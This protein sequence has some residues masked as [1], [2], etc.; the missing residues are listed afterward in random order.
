MND[1][2]ILTRKIPASIDADDWLAAIV[3]SSDDAIISK[4]LDGIITSWNN[5][6]ERIFGYKGDE[7]LG[8][9]ITILIPDRLL[10]QEEEI[11]QRIRT[12]GRVV[13][14]ETVRI[15]KD[16]SEIY[17]SLTISPIYDSGG[18]IAGISKIARDITEQ[19]LLKERE[20]QARA[21]MLVERRFRELIE[22]AP[23][24]ILQ[25]DALGKITIANQSAE[26]MFGYPRSELVGSKVDL[27]VPVASR[28]H[29]ARYRKTFSEAGVSRPMGW[30][31][32]LSARR[33]DGSEFPVEISLSPEQTEKGAF[34]TA[35]IRDVTDRKQA[36]QQI[37]VLHQSYMTELEARKKEA[38]RLNQLKS[39][40]VASVSHELRTPLHTII[41][42]AE[43]LTEQSQGP[44]NEKQMRFLQYIQKDSTHLLELINDLLDLSRIEAG[45]M[46]L[47]VIELSVS[48][49][50]REAI[51]G[52]RPFAV[53]KQIGIHYQSDLSIKVLADP[54]RLRQVLYN[55]LSNA[56]K[57]TEAGGDVMVRTELNGNTVLFTVEDTGIGIDPLERGRIFEKFYQVGNTTAGIR[58]GTGLGL[59]I[60]KQLIEMQGGLIWVES[61]PKKGSLFCF[62]LPAQP[63]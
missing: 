21:E 25:V 24:A 63:M 59:A 60:C 34:V 17:V 38:E 48:N 15:R 4:T 45:S 56:L 12:G 52:I 61:G 19:R 44:L 32:D 6:A 51:H 1:F 20:D 58:Q 10:H 50:V 46:R 42:F 41:G 54:L 18:R 3:E 43:L 2:T 26:L 33:K 22:K 39:D 28:S 40:F 62:T 23:D 9:S 27:L 13:H 35:V 7:V 11:L 47:Q 49:A 29:H 16:R 37:R 53:E 30:G 14:F 57:F 36:E 5:G 8:K 55:L 31:R